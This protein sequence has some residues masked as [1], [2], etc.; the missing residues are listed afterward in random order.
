M[1]TAC[2]DFALAIAKRSP[3]L[4]SAYDGTFDYWAP[5]QPPVTILFAALG[6]EIAVT[7]GRCSLAAEQEL[8][9]RIE[10]AISSDD[11]ELATAVATGLVESI[12]S[13]LAQDEVALHRVLS[14]FGE[15]TRSHARAWL[16]E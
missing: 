6:D 9:S 12:V 10:D 1:N 14:M 7:L 13:K 15:Q 16:S 2:S 4:Q 8:F 5:D 3:E 11:E